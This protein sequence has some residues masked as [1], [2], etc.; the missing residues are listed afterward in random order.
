L[1]ET[2]KGRRIYRKYIE[3]PGVRIKN[4]RKKE[5]ENNK[6]KLITQLLPYLCSKL[7]SKASLSIQTKPLRRNESSSNQF[8]MHLKLCKITK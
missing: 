3:I 2:A 6:Q 1:I 8:Q 7:P 4:G 5:L